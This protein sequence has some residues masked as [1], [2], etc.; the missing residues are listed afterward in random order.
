MW[1]NSDGRRLL[2]IHG[3]QD[4]C[5]VFDRIIP[6]LGGNYCV[7]AV[8][9]PGHGFSSHYPSGVPLDFLNDIIAIVCVLR[10]VQWK[11]ALVLGHSM[12]GQIGFFLTATFPEYV[13]KLIVIDHIFPT[14]GEPSATKFIRAHVNGFLALHNRLKTGQE[15]V[16]TYQEALE[17]L[18]NRTSVLT[19]EAAEIVLK[20]SLKTL[21][22]GF[23]FRMDQRLKL[24]SIPLLTKEHTLD[25]LSNIQCPVLCIFSS[26]RFEIYE[27]IF[28]DAFA[29]LRNKSNYLEK[30]VNGNHDFHQNHPE[31]VV[32]LISDFFAN[33]KC[34]L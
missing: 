8:D 33:E 31:R 12:G 28:A 10:H 21:P 25:L 18:T 24:N 22:N 13:E 20:R 29:V 23:T 19:R 1:G 3:K 27:T 32:R 16:Y 4:N 26:E 2:A 7:L 34:K 14:N 30:V 17:K 6:S 11:R 15:P 5:G 9:L